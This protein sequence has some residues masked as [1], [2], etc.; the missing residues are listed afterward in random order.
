MSYIGLYA[1]EELTKSLPMRKINDKPT[2]ILKFPYLN[3]GEKRTW[4]I[5]L[6]NQSMGE[7]EHLII[8]ASPPKDKNGEIKDGVG[9]TVTHSALST[10]ELGAT[11]RFLITWDVSPEHQVKA[12]PCSVGLTIEGV[13]TEET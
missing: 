4:E 3:A 9:V 11:H 10:L 13:I 7:I 12:G 1:D 5:Y 8:K 2:W 6:D